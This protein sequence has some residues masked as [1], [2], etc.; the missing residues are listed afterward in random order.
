MNQPKTNPMAQAAL[1]LLGAA[2]FLPFLGQ[3]HLFD[4]DEIN[5]AEAAREMLATGDWLTVRI[6]YEPFWEKP[7]LFIWMQALSMKLLGVGEYAARLPNALAGMLTLL[8]LYRQGTSLYDSRFGWLWALSYLGSVLPFFYFKSGIIDPWFNLFI[9]LGVTHLARFADPRRMFHKGR[10]LLLSAAF[11]GLAV[12]T[13]GPAGLLIF[14]LAAGFYRV[15]FGFGHRLRLVQVLAFG[16]VLGVVGGF[17]FLLQAAT[18]NWQTIQDFVVYQVRLFSTKDAGHG[19]FLLY[20][21]VVLLLGV[22][23][24]SLLALRSFRW[25]DSDSVAQQAA[26]RWMLVLFWVVLVLFTIV[27]TKI[28]HYSSMCYFPLTYLAAR[29]LHKV[30]REGW[31]LGPWLKGGLLAMGLLWAAFPAAL[32][33]VERN[34]EAILAAGWVKDRFAAGNLE[35]SVHWSGLE[36]LG[37]LVLLLS[38]GG[39]LWLSGRGRAWGH[40]LMLLGGAV[41]LLATTALVVPRVERYTQNAVVEFYQSI[42][43]QDA[44]VASRYKSYAHLFY[45][46]VPDHGRPEAYELPWLMQTPLDKPVYVVAKNTQA[47]ALEAEYPFLLKIEAKNGYVFYR[48]PPSR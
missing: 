36:P 4:W 14:L 42:A 31:R 46:R 39:G 5:F 19:G 11:V 34:K 44:Y 38:L 6:N 32:P 10:D 24:A 21:F 23:P 26:R 43:G 27:S 37:G 35:A 29:T 18:G 13:K 16:G 28:A 47:E 41:F 25:D 33:L 8:V 40:D 2:F 3:V 15:L 22:F 9:F 20:H 17:W 12:L 30:E 1:L 45:A 48:K 7:P